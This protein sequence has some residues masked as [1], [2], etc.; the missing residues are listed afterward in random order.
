MAV[1]TGLALPGRAQ[2]DGDWESYQTPE[3]AGF[4]SARLAQITDT[5]LMPTAG[6]RL[7]GV[8]TEATLFG[9]W[10]GSRMAGRANDQLYRMICYAFIVAAAIIGLVG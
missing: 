9:V 6:Q 8:D 3:E 10:V 7:Y 2:S 1:F 4:S 5:H